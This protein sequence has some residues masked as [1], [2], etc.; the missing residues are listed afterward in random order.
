[1]ALMKIFR[2]IVLKINMKKVELS[3]VFKYDDLRQQ[4][5]MNINSA[6]V[7]SRSGQWI[8]GRLKKKKIYLY[9]R[10]SD[11]LKARKYILR[12]LRNCNQLADAK[13]R[14]KEKTIKWGNPAIV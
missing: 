14:I 7:G 9:F 8:G 4:L 11:P 2:I 5:G 6:L 12:I 13:I 1:M 10:V 3:P